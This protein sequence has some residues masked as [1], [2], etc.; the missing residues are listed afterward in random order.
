[1]NNSFHKKTYFSCPL[2]Q[3]PNEGM[4]QKLKFLFFS[5][6]FLLILVQT[7]KV[8]ISLKL[9]NGLL[10]FFFFASYG[11]LGFLR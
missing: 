3:Q 2:P 4:K 5:Y 6:L 9:I 11:L 8:S 7:N 1:M 10:G